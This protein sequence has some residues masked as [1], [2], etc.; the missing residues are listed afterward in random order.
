M[1]RLAFGCPPPKKSSRH[2]ILRRR[3]PLLRHAY[4]A[5]ST[6]MLYRDVLYSDLW[7]TVNATKDVNLCHKGFAV[8]G[9][10]A[11]LSV[12]LK[13][14]THS[15]PRDSWLPRWRFRIFDRCKQGILGKKSM[16]HGI[17]SFC[18]VNAC[19][20]WICAFQEARVVGLSKIARMATTRK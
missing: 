9:S 18:L 5:V 15:V 6:V 1:Q 20:L 19:V 17:R 4:S 10:H 11:Q 16:I 3:R 2:G 12:F 13:W 14:W 7:Q 8:P